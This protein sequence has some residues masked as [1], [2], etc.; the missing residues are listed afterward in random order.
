MLIQFTDCTVKY[1]DEVLFSPEDGDFDFAV[2]KD[3]VSAFAGMADYR[4]FN[5]NTHNPSTTTTIKT[6]RSAKQKELIELY[7]AIRNYRNGETTKFSPDAVFDI[8]KKH[9]NEDWLL[10]LEIYEL[11]VERNTT[12]SKE[13]FRYLNELKERRPEVSH[14]IEG[15][16][17]LLETP[18]HV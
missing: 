15:G 12:L 6:E 9:H 4:S 5:V 11:E 14:L 8:L 10:P 17:E 3:I 7:E 2:G 1:K 18:E 13:V 16:L